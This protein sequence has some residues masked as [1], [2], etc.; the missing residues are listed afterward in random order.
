MSIV[1]CEAEQ[2]RE[3]KGEKWQE[4]EQII[5]VLAFAY[6][7]QGQNKEQSSQWV[8]IRGDFL[9]EIQ[10]LFY[11]RESIWFIL[12]H[13]LCILEVKTLK[14][15]ICDQILVEILRFQTQ[16]YLKVYNMCV[17]TLEIL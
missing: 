13:D 10:I 12:K 4:Q 16:H 9:Q 11:L 15:Q 17:H 1:Q 3:V 2:E 7:T 5:L 14:D 6:T 8:K